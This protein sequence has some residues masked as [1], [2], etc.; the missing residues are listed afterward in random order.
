MFTPTSWIWLLLLILLLL[1]DNGVVAQTPFSSFDVTN[2]NNWDWDDRNWALSTHQYIPGHY[3]TRL[4]LANGYFGASLA[5]AGPFF[6]IDI[7]STDPTGTQPLTVWPL[8]TPRLS[9]TTVSGFYNAQPNATGTNYPWLNQYGWESFIAGIPHSTAILFRF[10]DFLLDARTPNTSVSNFRSGISFKHGLGQWNYTWTPANCGASFNVSYTALFSRE[11]PNVAAV[12]ATIIPSSDI[13]GTVTDLLDGRSAVRSYLNKKGQSDNHTIYTSVHPDGLANITAWVVS[14][15]DTSNS[16]INPSSARTATGPGIP[17]NDTTMGLDYDISLKAGET[18]TFNKYVGVASNDKFSDAEMAARTAQAESQNLGWA[19]LLAE[20]TAGWEALLT[21]D[22]VDDYSDPVTGELPTDLNVKILHLSGIANAYYL[23]QQLQPDGS[24]LN[25][26]SVSVGGLVSDSYAGMVFWDADYWVAPGINVNR[27]NYAKQIPNFRVKQHPQA[28]ANAAFNNYTG[29]AA[30]YPWTAGRYGNCT[31]TGPCVDYEYHINPDISNNML[32]LR[33]ITNNAT[34]FDSGPKDVLL[35]IAE[36]FSQVVFYN[37]TTSTWWIR[38]MTDPD[39]YANNVD[40]GAFTIASAAKTFNEANSLLA[41]LG[42]PINETWA[43]MAEKIAFPRAP[44][45]ITLEFQTM[46]DSVEVKQAD[47]VLLAYPLDY[48][49]SNY[50]AE[51]KLLDLDFYANK[52]SSDGPAM[53]YSIFTIGANALS[54]SGCSPYT[55]A[56]GG[57]LPYLRAPFFQFSEQNDDNLLTNGG[58]NPAFPFLTGHGGAHQ[59]VP[60]GLLGLRSD[61]PVFF[62]NPSLFPQVTHVR[63]RTLHYAGASIQASLNR[64]HTTITRVTTPSSAGLADRYANTTMPIVLGAPNSDPATYT[65]YSL[66]INQTIY[67]PNRLY[68]E[69][70]TVPGNLLQCSSVTSTDAYARGQFPVAAIDGATSTGWQPVTNDTAAI[71]VNMTSIPTT[72]IAGISFDWGARPP[73][74]ATVYVGNNTNFASLVSTEIPFNIDITPSLP[75]NATAAAMSAEEVVPVVGN[76]TSFSL[77]GNVWTGDYARLVI[78]GCWEEDG[79]GATVREFVM[80]G[81]V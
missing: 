64:T 29:G 36:M 20:H 59:V 41:S 26:N 75:F 7:N 4:S 6:E 44:S 9:F 40:N 71:T 81:S 48:G 35:S 60:F 10:G 2:E 69:N 38:N 68:W 49:G 39:E 73:R 47:V 28:L 51:H 72:P 61:Q 45:G 54:Q 34:W 70:L 76:T 19:F 63:V 50:T 16:Y 79:A 11:R 62:I 74:N 18:A 43:E 33:N 57:S 52:Q 27:P 42:M 65:H 5:A 32:Q 31:G 12:K 25:D 46:D 67:V 77:P 80:L 13:S 17:T 53:T 21:P 58:Q 1:L 15:L 56:L 24:G 30:L 66:A 3:Q 23:L 55:Y 14:G 78:E 8:F 22:S 37:E